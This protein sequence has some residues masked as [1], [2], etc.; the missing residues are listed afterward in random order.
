MNHYIRWQFYLN[1]NLG[2]P[3]EG[4]HGVTSHCQQY[5]ELYCISMITVPTVG[6]LLWWVFDMCVENYMISETGNNKNAK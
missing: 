4:L 1:T 3:E 6:F 5:I 2:H